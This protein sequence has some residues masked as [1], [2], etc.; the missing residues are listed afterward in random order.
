MDRAT[1][2]CLVAGPLTVA[3]TH[4]KVAQAASSFRVLRSDSDQAGIGDTQ[5]I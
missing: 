3:R 2:Q 4:R 1:S 5:G